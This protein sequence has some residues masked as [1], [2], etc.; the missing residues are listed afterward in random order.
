MSNTT[1]T[2]LLITILA[3]IA[4]A[5]AGITGLNDDGQLFNSN[6]TEETPIVIDE[7]LVTML[8]QWE[9]TIYNNDDVVVPNS[10]NA[11][12]AQFDN[13]GQF[14][15]T[16]DC[17]NVMGTYVIEEPSSLSFGPLAATRKACLEETQ[18]LAYT[19][20]LADITQYMIDEEGRLVLLLQYDSGSMIFSPFLEMNQVSSQEE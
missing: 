18:E 20:M 8:W 6:N 17:N 5:V 14:A 2:I 15:S 10:E 4:L 19:Q 7:D 1:K 9:E 13:Q 12:I 3:L 16:T 11:F